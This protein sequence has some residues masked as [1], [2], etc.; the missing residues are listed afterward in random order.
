MMITRDLTLT[1]RAYKYIREKL[2]SGEL[3]PGTRLVN[4]ALAKEIGTSAIP[5]REAISRLISE[6]LVE[7]VPSAGAYVRTR[8]P[9]ELSDM[10]DLR[11]AIE[12]VAAAKA[13]EHMSEH[14]VEELQSIVDDWREM[15]RGLRNRPEGRL[16]PA[17]VDRWRANEQRF[18]QVIIDAA[19]NGL[20]SKFARELH[21]VGQVFDGL[22]HETEVIAPAPAE[23]MCR[24]YEAM[25]AAIR[26]RDAE[27]L[28]TLVHDHIRRSRDAAIERLR[29]P[30]GRRRKK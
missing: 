11:E 19:R 9:Q 6:G 15:V 14:E 21:V 24:S 3:A 27:K 29:R 17:Q 2:V 1:E 4:R 25:L 5:V 13:A 23:Q 20:M 10:F 30:D 18:H 7:Y 8:S 12:P 22:A 28:R 26:A 16:S